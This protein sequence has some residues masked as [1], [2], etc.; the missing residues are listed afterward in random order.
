MDLQMKAQTTHTGEERW[1]NIGNHCIECISSDC[2][3]VGLF[4]G[5]CVDLGKGHNDMCTSRRKDAELTIDWKLMPSLCR[6]DN[7]DDKNQD[8]EER[9][10]K[11]G[12]PDNVGDEPDQGIGDES[13]ECSADFGD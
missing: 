13:D 7:V 6:L 2:A 11:L 1:T 9:R 5:Y 8:V 10:Q 4:V 12:R 3:I